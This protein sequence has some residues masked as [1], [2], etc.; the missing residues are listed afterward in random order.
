MSCGSYGTL[1]GG[2][3]LDT[4]SVVLEICLSTFDILCL[5][6]LVAPAE[7]KQN[8]VFTAGELHSVTRSPGDTQL[9]YA[10][11]YCLAIP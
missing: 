6:R 8:D 11:A 7:Q 1:G 4:P 3:F 5:C 10:L 2:G 9:Q